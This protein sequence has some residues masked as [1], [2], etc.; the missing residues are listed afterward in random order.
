[1]NEDVDNDEIINDINDLSEF[2]DDDSGNI[3][4]DW[5]DIIMSFEVS[6]NF[7][8][9]HFDKIDKSL[10][11]EHQQL[12]LQFIIDNITVFD[13]DE[14]IKFQEIEDPKLITLLK[15]YQNAPNKETIEEVVQVDEEVVEPKLLEEVFTETD[16]ITEIED[17]LENEIKETIVMS[18]DEIEKDII[19]DSIDELN[20]NEDD[21]EEPIKDNVLDIIKDEIE[22]SEIIEEN[23]YEVVEESILRNMLNSHLAGL[24]IQ[25]NS[26]MFE[27]LAQIY[28]STFKCLESNY[29]KTSK[30]ISALVNAD[31]IVD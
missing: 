20:F 7:I 10:L 18:K 11:L 8:N 26:P 29:I 31:M 14:V 12:R 17:N 5:K 30:E 24:G 19:V 2:Y 4:Y 6:E 16:I 28:L 1:M 15:Q 23:K 22:K 3:E 13:I 9:D 21:I 27:H 25:N